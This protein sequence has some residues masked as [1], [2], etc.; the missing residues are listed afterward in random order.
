MKKLYLF[1]VDQFVDKK[2]VGTISVEDL[3]N[4]SDIVMKHAIVKEVCWNKKVD[5]AEAEGKIINMFE[6][7]FLY[8]PLPIGVDRNKIKPAPV[9][10][11]SENK[12]FSIDFPSTREE[13]V[14]FIDDFDVRLDMERALMIVS[15][16][17]D[18][19][20]SRSDK[21]PFDIAIELLLKPSLGILKKEEYI[22]E[23]TNGIEL[24]EVH[25]SIIKGV[26]YDAKK[27]ILYVRFANE[28]MYAY[29][30]V[31]VDKFMRLANSNSVGAYFNKHI[32]NFYPYEKL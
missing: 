7:G 12:L 27:Q 10:G 25:S 17:M 8:K 9:P 6:E 19:R 1:E 24:Q 26:G 2:Y 23:R 11:E 16:Y 31:M 13:F 14:G 15:L 32:R 28:N 5:P 4:L 22:L 29:S 18:L 21:P 20:H 3:F 30:H